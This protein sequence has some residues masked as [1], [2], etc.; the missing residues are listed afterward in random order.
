MTS[1]ALESRADDYRK[2]AAHARAQA[3]EMTDP[4]A[5]EAMLCV[6]EQWD[7]MAAFEEKVNPP[8]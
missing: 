4:K 7:R 2:R 5:R 6:A 3:G 8:T 1:W